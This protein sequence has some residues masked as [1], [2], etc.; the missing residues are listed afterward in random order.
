M[1]NHKADFGALDWEMPSPGMRMKVCRQG[2]TQVRL[3]E[4]AKDFVEPDWCL[5]GHV[6]YV[7]DGRI[8]VDFHGEVEAFGP[9][10]GIIISS[11]AEHKHKARALTNTVTLFLTERIA[12]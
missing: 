3:V 1:S 7:L 9:G 8:E 6:G 10:D 4:F 2:D 11:G 5:R 12:E